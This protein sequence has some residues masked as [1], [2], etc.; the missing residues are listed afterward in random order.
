ML[1]AD[2]AMLLTFVVIVVT[3][4]LYAM[5]RLALEVVAL[6]SVVAFLL[7]FTFFQPADPS[8]TVSASE[9][10]SGFANPALVTVICLLIVGQGSVPD[11]RAGKTGQDHRRRHAQ[12]ANSGS[13]ADTDCGGSDQ[14]LPEQ[15]PGRGDVP[16]HPLG[17]RR[18]PGQAGRSPADAPIV[19]RH[20]RWHDDPDRLVHQPSGGRCGGPNK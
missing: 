19:H 20:S 11:G 12:T 1:P 7:I 9:L 15:H 6:G 17:S 8:V 2:P 13:G 14:R 16:A 3:V 5:E 4:V 10:L 18:C